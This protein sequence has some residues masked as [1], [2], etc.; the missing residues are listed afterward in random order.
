L[1]PRG[2][3]T[4]I[5]PPPL[6]RQKG[7]TRGV[8]WEREKLPFPGPKNGPPKT[9]RPRPEKEFPGPKEGEI[10]PRVSWEPGAAPPE[11]ALCSAGEEPAKPGGPFGVGPP[12]RIALPG[13]PPWGPKRER[14]CLTGYKR[15]P[16]A[17]G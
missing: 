3:L 2:G 8:N 16:E 15:G 7:K 5:R 11:R 10:P 13:G 14:G 1:P 4:E 12:K 6:A 17:P 9:H